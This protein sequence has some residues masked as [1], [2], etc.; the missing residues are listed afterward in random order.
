MQGTLRIVYR[1]RSDRESFLAPLEVVTGQLRPRGGQQAGQDAATFGI[2]LLGLT[3]VLD[4][5]ADYI[6]IGE[7]EQS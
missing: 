2:Q 5:C 1:R 3:Q 6:F 4:A 7:I